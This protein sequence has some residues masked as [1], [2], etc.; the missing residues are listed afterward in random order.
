MSID[1]QWKYLNRAVPSQTFE[2]PTDFFDS[3]YTGSND[4]VVVQAHKSNN[5]KYLLDWDSYLLSDKKTVIT[6]RRFQNFNHYSEWKRLR[7]LLPKLDFNVSEEE[8]IFLDTM[9]GNYS[10]VHT[11]TPTMDYKMWDESGK[12][13]D[14]LDR[15]KQEEYK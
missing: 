3:L 5:D 4:P 6:F 2:D 1:T 11:T 9:S 15:I 14:G 12:I 8:G 13:W 10:W 7:S